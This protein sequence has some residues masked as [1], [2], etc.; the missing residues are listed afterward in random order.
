MLAAVVAVVGIKRRDEDRLERERQELVG[1]L[2]RAQRSSAEVAD[3]GAPV[4]F[5]GDLHCGA[6]AEEID[7]TIYGATGRE[8]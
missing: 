5:Y 1:R 6:D 4:H 3:T 8:S 2:R 7:T